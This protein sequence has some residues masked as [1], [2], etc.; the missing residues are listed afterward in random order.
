MAL[1]RSLPGQ[2]MRAPFPYKGATNRCLDG[3]GMA[4]GPDPAF[5]TASPLGGVS[6]EEGLIE[7][8]NHPTKDTQEPL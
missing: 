6:V 2:G 1:L 8:E 4:K 3:L 7:L 5:G